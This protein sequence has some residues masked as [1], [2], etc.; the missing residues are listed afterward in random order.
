MR[1][2]LF[3][4]FLLGNTDDSEDFFKRILYII[5]N[6]A[7][8]CTMIESQIMSVKRVLFFSTMS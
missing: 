3:I 2:F 1:G 5:K 8:M 4:Y 7:K 6:F